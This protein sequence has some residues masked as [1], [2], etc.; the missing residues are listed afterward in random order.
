MRRRNPLIIPT[1]FRR[2]LRVVILFPGSPARDSCQPMAQRQT[3]ARI[4][5][6]GRQQ[7]RM[8]RCSPWALTSLINLPRSFILACCGRDVG[9][10]IKAMRGVSFLLTIS[11]QPYH[12]ITI[13]T[14]LRYE[15][16]YHYRLL[17]LEQT[18]RLERS[19]STLAQKY[20]ISKLETRKTSKV[21]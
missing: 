19:L 12:I 1:I 21:G 18:R 7:H 11:R 5:S 20:G 14:A 10:D 6:Q 4:L 2:P 3:W 9:K 16:Q 17:L 13:A 15:E 8:T